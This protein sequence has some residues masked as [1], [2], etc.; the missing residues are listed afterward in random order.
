MQI[1]IRGKM[2]AIFMG[3]AFLFYFSCTKDKTDNGGGLGTAPVAKFAIS[4]TKGTVG[5][6]ITFSDG[7]T[8]ADNDIKSYKWDFADGST[9]ATSKNTTY[10]YTRAGS[11]LVTLT[12]TD[13]KNNGSTATQRILVI[14]SAAPDYG[15]LGKGIKEA[16]AEL[17]PKTFVC[18]H[19][20]MHETVPENSVPAIEAAIANKINVVEIDVRLTLDKEVAIMHDATTART[21]NGNLSVAQSTMSELKKLKLLFNGVP[22]SFEVPTFKECLTAAK[23]KVYIDVDMSWDNSLSYYN[24]IYNEVAAMNM[25]SMVFFYTESPEVAKGMMELDSDVIVLLGAGN[26]TNWNNANNLNPKARLWHLSSGT[27]SPS[28]TAGPFA[29]GIR[30]FANAYVNSTTSPPLSG[31]DAVVDNLTN[32]KVSIIQTDFPVRVKN[33]LQA[34]GLWI[35]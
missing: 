19:R 23:G 33:Y 14:N 8:D 18:A 28:F 30:F 16:I 21:A 27:L 9:A 35:P 5:Q 24:K 13:S 29:E 2:P 31:A 34:K 26:A 20:A 6:T 11:Y 3:F 22:T 4:V 7:S 1:F 15:S 17:H 12:V 32:N 25:V 10:A